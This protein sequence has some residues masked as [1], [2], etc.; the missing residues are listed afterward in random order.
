MTGLNAFL[1]EIELFIEVGIKEFMYVQGFVKCNTIPKVRLLPSR[2]ANKKPGIVTCF[3]QKPRQTESNKSLKI[4]H[5]KTFY[6]NTSVT[7]LGRKWRA[8]PNQYLRCTLP[9]NVGGSLRFF[10]SMHRT[11]RFTTNKNR[12]YRRRIGIAPVQNAVT[13]NRR[14]P[15]VQARLCRRNQISLS[16]RW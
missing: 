10:G 5:L 9:C 12:S 14:S 1:V 6:L 7:C 4:K 15:A 8:S 11:T 2:G 3:E 16:A 13:E